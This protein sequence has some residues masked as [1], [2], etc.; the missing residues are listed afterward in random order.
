M[1]PE[2]AHAHLE[3]AHSTPQCPVRAL[4]SGGGMCPSIVPVCPL[5]GHMR[6]VPTCTRTVHVPA[7]NQKPVPPQKCPCAGPYV[8]LSGMCRV[9]HVPCPGYVRVLLLVHDRDDAAVT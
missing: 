2:R 9:L 7:E 5:K 4:V 3:G 8:P 6:H 1:H